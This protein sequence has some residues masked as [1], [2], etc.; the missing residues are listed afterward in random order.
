M[1]HQSTDY[2]PA[3]I[4]H[5]LLLRQ[6]ETSDIATFT[7]PHSSR[8]KK[9]VTDIQLSFSAITTKLEQGCTK[10]TRKYTLESQPD[11]KYSS[12]HNGD[13]PLQFDTNPS[14]QSLNRRFPDH[15]PTSFPTSSS[16]EPGE[17]MLMGSSSNAVFASSPQTSATS[18]GFD[19]TRSPT[20]KHHPGRMSSALL[21]AY[22]HQHTT[23][24]AR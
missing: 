7:P 10:K 11:Q 3:S 5:A 14:W 24:T 9:I 17:W 20:S 22:L 18:L 15:L 13:M 6:G 23:H 2:A 16:A 8:I 21:V 19:S 4:I 12:Y 1:D